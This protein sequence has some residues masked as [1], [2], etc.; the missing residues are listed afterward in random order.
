MKKNLKGM[1]LPTVQR[2][3]VHFLRKRNICCRWWLCCAEESVFLTRYAKHVTI[4]IREDDFSCASSIASLAKNHEKITVYTNVEVLEVSGHT[5][6]ESLKYHN[7]K[8]N[9]VIEYHANENDTFG[10]FVFA[11]YQPNTSCRTQ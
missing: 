2:V 11:G 9:E 3:M 4:L 8:T 1:V 7:K 10:V 5:Y 6:L